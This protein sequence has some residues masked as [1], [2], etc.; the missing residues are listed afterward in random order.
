MH[1]SVTVLGFVTDFADQGVILPLIAAVA[2]SL[3]LN[4][5]W[6]LACVWLG[7]TSFVL[8]ATL[9]LKVGCYL[10]GV[11]APAL[12][13]QQAGL[14]SPSGHVAAACIAYGGLV[15]LFARPAGSGRVACAVSL[16]IAVVVGATRV[17]LGDHS[18]GEV[19]IGAAIGTVGAVSFTVFAARAAGTVSNR[20]L[21]G[22]CL[23]VLLLFHG[24]HLSFEQTIH[25][26][27]AEVFNNL[28]QLRAPGW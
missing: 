7:A 4:A 13:L 14:V 5:R 10:C 18:W 6:R 12:G 24:V 3:G 2:V 23:P 20:A 21:I 27:S 17:A 19:V 15:A 16:A 25:H 28:G 8:G 22:A 26:A 9:A 1:D 11:F